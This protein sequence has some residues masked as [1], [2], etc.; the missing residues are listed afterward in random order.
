MFPSWLLV[1]LSANQTA[2]T[3]IAKT[4][5]AIAQTGQELSGLREECA[6]VGVVT[7]SDLLVD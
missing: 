3:I 1:L 4:I 5:G 2:M 7:G 6:D